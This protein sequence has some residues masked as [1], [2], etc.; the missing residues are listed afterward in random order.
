MCCPPMKK[1][2]GNAKTDQGVKNASDVPPEKTSEQGDGESISAKKLAF[3]A[4][5]VSPEECRSGAAVSALRYALA[6][7]MESKEVV[8]SYNSAATNLEGLFAFC[9]DTPQEEPGSGEKKEHVSSRKARYFEC[10]SLSLGSLSLVRILRAILPLYP[11]STFPSSVLFS[12]RRV[13]PAVARWLP[14]RPGRADFPHPVLPVEV[15][16][17]IA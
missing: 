15:P 2:S 1:N 5:I 14:H 8:Q 10:G 4:A 17:Q 11:P 7:F 3:L 16:H 6:L 12:S 9:G 13:E